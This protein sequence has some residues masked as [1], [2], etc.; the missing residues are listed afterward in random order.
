[1]FRVLPRMCA[2]EP[3]FLA[4]ISPH[5]LQLISRVVYVKIILSF[6]HFGHATDI[7]LLFGFGIIIFLFRILLFSSAK[8]GY[9][10]YVFSFPSS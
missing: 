7:K 2:L 1:M 9:Q 8:V 3:V 6:S 5:E 4:T 10:A